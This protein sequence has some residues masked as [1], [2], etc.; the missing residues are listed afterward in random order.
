MVTAQPTGGKRARQHEPLLAD[1]APLGVGRPQELHEPRVVDALERPGR[2]GPRLTHLEAGALDRPKDE[3]RARGSLEAWHQLTAVKFHATVV[4]SV[5]CGMDDSHSG[6]S[7][8][9]RAVVLRH[10]TRR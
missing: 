3:V 5:Q 10:R 7:R 6:G 2:K 4:S 8:G 9:R 1:R